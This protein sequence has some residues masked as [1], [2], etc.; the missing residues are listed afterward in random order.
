MSH[1]KVDFQAVAWD[2]GREGVRFKVV[3]RETSILRLVEFMTAEGFE[4]WCE[5]GHIGLVL[6]GGLEIDF[7]GTTVA[8]SAGDGLYIPAGS[9]SAHRAVSIIPG[10]RLFMVEDMH[11]EHS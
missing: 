2:E 5:E 7:N 9:A 8:Y 4:Q 1:Y 10:T 3:H 11:Q 6:E